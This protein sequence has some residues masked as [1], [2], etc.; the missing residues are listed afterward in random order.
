M[1]GSPLSSHLAFQQALERQSVSTRLPLVAVSGPQ[2]P[3]GGSGLVVRVDGKWFGGF[4]KECRK[5]PTY[6]V[7]VFFG[8]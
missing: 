5:P 1:T 6:I 8:C 2:A 4:K 3:A 7:G